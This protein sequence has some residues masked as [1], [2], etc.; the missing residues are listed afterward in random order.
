LSPRALSKR[1]C[2]SAALALKVRART[3]SEQTTQSAIPTAVRAAQL[4]EQIER[5]EATYRIL[6]ACY[7]RAVLKGLRRIEVADANSQ[8]KYE[9]ELLTWA[10]QLN[11]QHIAYLRQL[12]ATPQEFVRQLAATGARPVQRHGRGLFCQARSPAGRRRR[13]GR[14]WL[15]C[16][17]TIAPAV[18]VTMCSRNRDVHPSRFR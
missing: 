10:S 17:F 18:P 14:T 15:I 8:A 13:V 1:S 12:V 4:A 9:R 3:V 11:D 2:A 16:P 7:E 6:R 5:A